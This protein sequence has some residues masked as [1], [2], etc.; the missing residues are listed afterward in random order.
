MRVHL[1]LQASI[2]EWRHKLTSWKIEV[3]GMGDRDPDVGVDILEH[4]LD[5]EEIRL[6]KTTCDDDRDLAHRGVR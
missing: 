3:E 6:S 5:V 1:D 2:D 4:P